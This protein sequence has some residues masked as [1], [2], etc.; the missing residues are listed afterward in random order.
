MVVLRDVDDTNK[1]KS[2]NMAAAHAQLAGHGYAVREARASAP[3][4]DQSP[5]GP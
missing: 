5:E 4:D 2:I 1:L 3:G